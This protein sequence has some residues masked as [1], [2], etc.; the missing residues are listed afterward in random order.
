MYRRAY[1]TLLFLKNDIHQARHF[2]FLLAC[3]EHLQGM[4]IN[5]HKSDLLTLNTSEE[6]QNILAR[7]FCCN[8][9]SFPI[10]YLVVPQHLLEYIW[11]F[12]YCIRTAIHIRWGCLA[13]QVLYSY[14]YR[15]RP[16]ANTIHHYTNSIILQLSPYMG[17][18]FFS[19]I[20]CIGLALDNA[21]FNVFQG[22]SFET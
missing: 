15:P 5:Y 22:V 4:K 1:D 13:P 12:R 11:Q 19:N 16:Q 7:L 21:M 9:S 3:F 6:E 14:I 2:K 18:R 10:K 8:I 20:D 17:R